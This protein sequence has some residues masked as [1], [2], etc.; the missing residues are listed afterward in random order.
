MRE[1]WTLFITFFRIGAVTFGGGYAMLPIL[2]REL[3]ETRGWATEEE[4][5]D[6][7]AISQ[8]T[9]GVIAVN[10]STFIGMKRRGVKGACAATFGVVAP[11]LV[12]ITLIA[13]VLTNYIDNP[14]VAHAFAGIRVVVAVLIV[15]AV[16]RLIKMGVKGV[17]G[18]AVFAVS[19]AAA[20][21]L[22]VSPIAVV[23]AAA[24][25]GIIYDTARAVKTQ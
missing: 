14:Y 20:M 24:A 12:I 7:Y 4:L 6:Y 22:P 5:L 3:V 8:V 19:F 21:Y 10:V 25:A 17:F 11:S 2:K 9:P 1:L 16:V 13:T 23:S 18:Y 15:N